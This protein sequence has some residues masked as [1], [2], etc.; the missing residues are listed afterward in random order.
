MHA[1]LGQLLA[2]AQAAGAVRPGITDGL[3]PPA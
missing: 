3:R 2:Q 1:C